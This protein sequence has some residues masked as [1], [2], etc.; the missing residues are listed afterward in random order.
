MR[1][2][3]SILLA[4]VLVVTLSSMVVLASTTTDVVSTAA[5][6][7]SSR[8]SA[9]QHN[10]AKQRELIEW[11]TPPTMAPHIKLPPSTSSKT[12]ASIESSSGGN[13][14]AVDISMLAN[15][16]NNNDDNTNDNTSRSS[17]G[18]R[19]FMSL[20]SSSLCVGGFIVALNGIAHMTGC[21]CLEVDDE[22][23]GE[24]G[25]ALKGSVK[26]RLSTF[27]RMVVEPS[28]STVGIVETYEV[29]R[30]LSD[31]DNITTITDKNHE[32]TI[33]SSNNKTKNKRTFGSRLL[34]A[35]NAATSLKNI[36]RMISINK[37]NKKLP[38]SSSKKESVVV[39]N[40]NI[41][42]ASNTTMEDVDMN[43]MNVY[44]RENDDDERDDIEKNGGGMIPPCSSSSYKPPNMIDDSDCERDSII[45]MD[46]FSPITRSLGSMI[47]PYK[48]DMSDND[49]CEERD[50]ISMDLFTPASR[51]RTR[52]L[53]SI[54]ET[55]ET[56]FKRREM[57][58]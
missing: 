6:R 53:G 49:D 4:T 21:P 44:V 56:P 1:F 42:I 33:L 13:D 27:N 19:L 38:K 57:L 55:K 3:A 41:I 9:L 5:L 2:K 22:E 40:N 26:K 31:F 10:M 23:T 39:D 54:H 35:T 17:S 8:R 48:R 30:M 43:N 58:L 7:S 25:H 14:D 34:S 45:T 28:S 18:Y 24:R 52:S 51:T 20:L 37:K 46:L 11:S 15:A 29:P 12:G 47:P 16:S 50:N 32:T 36:K